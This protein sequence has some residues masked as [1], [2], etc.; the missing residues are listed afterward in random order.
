MS[1]KHGLSYT[2]EYR[3]WQTMRLRC[4]VPSNPAYADYG[5]RGITVCQRWLTSVENFVADMGP[6]PGPR[7]ELDRKDNSKG[8]DPDNCRW[9][10]RTV[11]CRNR[12]S[13]RWVQFQGRRMVLVEA[14][15]LSGVP[16]ATV[17]KRLE[18]GWAEDE[19]LTTPARHISPKGM[20]PKRPPLTNRH[21]FKGVKFDRE[22]QLYIACK[23]VNGKRFYSRRF[24]TAE[25]A[26]QAYL[27]L[28]EP[29]AK[30]PNS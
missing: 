6:K 20:G 19:A 10:T 27:K 2:P 18:N 29:D 30:R 9:A 25:E 8:Y 14:I 1:T 26:H 4:T 15:E 16:L 17:Y 13:N 7:Y 21:G 3:A 11:N 23:L 22:R 28:G 12:R 5:G 24:M